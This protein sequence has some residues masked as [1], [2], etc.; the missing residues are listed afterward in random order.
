MRAR[1][2]ALPPEEERRPCR[3]PYGPGMATVLATTGG[4]IRPP[5]SHRAHARPK[6]ARRPSGRRVGNVQPFGACRPTSFAAV[7]RR[8]WVRRPLS[9]KSEKGMQ[10]LIETEADGKY[11]RSMR[12]SGATGWLLR[13]GTETPPTRCMPPG[14]WPAGTFLAAGAAAPE[15]VG[16]GRISPRSFGA[17]T[18]WSEG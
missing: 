3:G 4:A 10:Q 16:R 13:A 14:H 15:T 5:K 11:L 7:D 12:V 8:V 1:E 9:T 6:R 17:G 18:K 2:A